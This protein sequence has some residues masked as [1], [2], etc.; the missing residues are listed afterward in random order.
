MIM[1]S[2]HFEAVL[3]RS[4]AGRPDTQRKTLAGLGLNRVGK[5]VYL[6]DTPAV[7]GM[8]YKVVHLVEVRQL[9]GEVPAVSARARKRAAA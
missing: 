4:S 7:R 3:K 9:E 2:T 8:L 6:K 5:R 1:P